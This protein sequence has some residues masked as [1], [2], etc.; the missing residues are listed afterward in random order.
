MSAVGKFYIVCAP[1]VPNAQ[2]CYYNNN[3]YC[4]IHVAHV[5]KLESQF[6]ILESQKAIHLKKTKHIMDSAF[7]HDLL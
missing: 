7:P 2:T 6:T 5:I 4:K 3:K 1:F